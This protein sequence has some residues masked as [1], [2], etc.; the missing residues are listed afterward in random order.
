MT[1]YFG[2]FFVLLCAVLAGFR[3]KTSL[4][5]R[6][7]YCLATALMIAC[8]GLRAESVGRDYAMYKLYFDL[9][10]DTVG[11]GF[12][13]QWTSTM[14]IVDVA[15]VYLNS[16]VRMIGLP[17]EA[18]VFLL[19]LSVVTLYAVFFWEHARFS[20]FALMVYFS[21][22]FLNKEMIQIRDGAAS[23]IA[24]WAFHFWA[25]DRKRWGQCTDAVGGL[26]PYG[27]PGRRNPAGDLPIQMGGQTLVRPGNSADRGI[28][29]YN[30]SSSVSV[31]FPGRS[32]GSLSG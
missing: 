24:L 14:A 10:P 31:L 21:H 32:P 29:G 12:L 22:A 26:D 30:L 17:F 2:I 23:V 15:Y 7:V 9:S 5:N 18:L 3:P 19:A 1:I 6:G 20:A 8:A 28:I 16:L 4:M 13:G 25:C 27:G 11:P